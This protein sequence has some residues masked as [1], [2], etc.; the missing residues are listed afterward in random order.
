MNEQI[1]AIYELRKEQRWGEAMQL[2]NELLEQDPDNAFVQ[3]AWA[4]CKFDTIKSSLENQEALQTLALF[5]GSIAGAPLA[6]SQS[7]MH[8]EQFGWKLVK[9]IA[10]LIQM[11]QINAERIWALVPPLCVD[12]S[13]AHARAVLKQLCRIQPQ[14][15]SFLKVWRI[16]GAEQLGE[17]DFEPEE[18]QGRT[19]FSLAETYANALGKAL[20]AGCSE[21]ELNA[22]GVD[23]ESIVEWLGSLRNQYPQFVWIPYYLL[24]WD[25]KN[26][27]R[28]DFQAADWPFLQKHLKDFW[29]W[30]L[31][32]NWCQDP[33]LRISA[34]AKGLLCSANDSFK[35]KLHQQA[36]AQLLQQGDMVHAKYELDRVIAIRQDESW[37]ISPSLLNAQVANWYTSTPLIPQAAQKKWYQETAQLAEQYMNTL[38]EA[39]YV[40]IPHQF[41]VVSRGPNDKGNYI[42]QWSAHEEMGI[43]PNQAALTLKVG[44]LLEIVVE[45]TKSHDGRPHSRIVHLRP[46]QEAVLTNW[47]KRF[48]GKLVS[49]LDK[50]QQSI[51]FCEDVF[52][53]PQ[54]FKKSAEGNWVKGYAIVNNQGRWSAIN[55][56]FETR[57][58]LYSQRTI[59]DPLLL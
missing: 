7:A 9:L 19:L 58:S 23:I 38:G 44:Q 30:Q 50:H 33:A 17:A 15:T 43:S 57:N 59:I 16:W 48:E 14:W 54:F 37:N 28:T 55:V 11:R 4:W 20:L 1:Q 29:L 21:D 26:G 47:F 40:S 53:G 13:E 32:A 25:F 3:Q 18:Y 52:I 27:R 8:R 10:Q 24:Q 51:G 39:Y 46:A 34:I 5:E 45:Q 6:F 56:V 41:A 49:K 2:A 12:G 31:L 35:I 42:I 22:E 36:Y